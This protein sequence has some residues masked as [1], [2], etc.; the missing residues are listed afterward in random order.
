M[1]TMHLTESGSEPVVSVRYTVTIGIMINFGD[2][3]DGQKE[4]DV[5]CK[6]TCSDDDYCFIVS[7]CVIKDRQKMLGR[8]FYQ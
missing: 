2:D 1:E 3:F 6:Q 7:T 5:T 8:F 4:G